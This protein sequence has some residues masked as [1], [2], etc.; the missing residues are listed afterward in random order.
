MTRRYQFASLGLA[1]AFAI[2]AAG[3]LSADPSRKPA[4]PPRKK[5][6]GDKPAGESTPSKKAKPAMPA[7]N[8]KMKD[9]DGKPQ[10]LRQYEGYVVLM[11][12]VASQ[13]GLTPQYA[14]LQKLY[15]TY[16]DRGFVVLGFP[17]N[18]FGKQEPGTNAEIREFCTSKFDVTFPMFAKVVVKGDGICPLYKHLTDGKATHGKGGD[19]EWNF[20][21]FLIDRNGEVV[22]RYHPR[23]SPQ[24][25][26]LIARL[27]ELLAADIPEDSPLARKMK[28]K[29]E[30]EEK[31]KNQQGEASGSDRKTPKKDKE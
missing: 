24:D 6:A 12:N 19:I 4:D 25:A 15:E 21:K 13:C 17:A 22:E 11:V 3:T 1:T 30:K 9:I 28:E 7:L 20:A 26:R 18:D 8:F 16:E 29:K 23:S 14:G 10:D 2:A 31:E 5:D 27:E